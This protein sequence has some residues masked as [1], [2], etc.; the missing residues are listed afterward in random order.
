MNRVED[1]V[2][3]RPAERRLAAKQLIENRA[4]AV[5]VAGRQHIGL[6]P[7][8]LLGGDI[9]RSTQDHAG[10][11]RNLTRIRAVGNA[12]IHEVDGTLGIET[13]VRRLDV[14][15]DDSLAMSI[16]QCLGQLGDD[17]RSAV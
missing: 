1:H 6:P 3:G 16:G 8:S 10:R 7:L 17:L 15:M 2:R 12:K 4:Q 11:K 9:G 5:L 14:A 13:D